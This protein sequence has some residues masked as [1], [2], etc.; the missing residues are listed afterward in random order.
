MLRENGYP[1]VD[2]LG[3]LNT[4]LERALGAAVKKKYATDFFILYRFPLAVRPFY[5]MPAPDSKDYSNSFDVFIRGEE[6]ISGAQRV[7]DADLLTG[8]L[9]GEEPKKNAGQKRRPAAFLLTTHHQKNPQPP[10]KN[11]Q[12]KQFKN[13]ARHR[14]RRPCRV[15]PRLHRLVP[16]GRP[17]AR[18]RGR[19]AG[20][21][22]DALLRPQQ[23]P[24]DEHVPARPEAPGAVKGV[25]VSRF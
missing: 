2:P 5:T 7:H 14:V 11:P 4:E 21:R 22:R 23:H 9:Y 16:P 1:D 8:E 17:A 19:G 6:I 18:R 3:D 10:T 25:R 20:A 24:Q 15:D 13:R 12:P